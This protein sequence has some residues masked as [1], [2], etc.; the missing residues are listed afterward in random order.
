MLLLSKREVQS[1]SN[2]NLLYPSTQ[3]FLQK[4]SDS[5]VSSNGWK[6]LARPTVG[7]GL[8]AYPKGPGEQQRLGV[9]HEYDSKMSGENGTVY[10]KFQM[11]PNAGN[12]I[13]ST[14]KN[15][16]DANGGTHAIMA[17]MLVKKDG[18][19]EDVSGGSQ[20]DLWAS[21]GLPLP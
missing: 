2:E 19:K 3:R 11:R 1:T 18:T 16:R 10:H 4:V 14:I 9:H 5:V 20:G 21:R 13:P 8:T 17:N 15:W 6:K 12:D 7:R